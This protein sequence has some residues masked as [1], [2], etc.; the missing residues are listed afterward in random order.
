MHR[1]L[2]LYLTMARISAVSFGGGYAVLPI[3]QRELVDKRGWV[4]TEDLSDISAIAQ[5]TPGVIIVNAAT[6]VGA[7][8]GGSAGA[9][10]ATLGILTPPILIMSLV[11]AFLWPYLQS[12]WAL[13]A[14][15]G[16]Q[17]C[18]CALI[19]HAVVRLFRGAVV[20][21]SSFALFAAALLLSFFTHLS[22]ILLVLAAG[23]LGLGIVRLRGRKGAGKP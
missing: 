11:A 14:L 3:L 7:Q 5:C 6:Y 16:L 17:A 13:H 4:T 10:C 9:L 23:L 1:N 2:Q 22:P 8:Y 18:V 12:P 20:D 19:L 15:A 21:L